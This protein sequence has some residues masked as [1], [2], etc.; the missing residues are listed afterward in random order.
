MASYAFSQRTVA[1]SFSDKNWIK[2]TYGGYNHCILINRSTGSVLPNCVAYVHGRW[3]ELLTNAIGLSKAKEYEA[4]MCLYNAEQYFGYTQDGFSRGQE[5]KLGAILCWRKGSLASGDGAGHVAI[6]EQINSDGSIVC[7]ASN[8]GGTRWYRSTYKKSN[9]Y[10]IGSSYTFQGF[11]YPPVEFSAF[12]TNAVTRDTNR[13][14]VH[15]GLDILNVRTGAGLGYRR[16]GYAERGYYNPISS[17]SADGYTWYQVEEG[18]WIASVQ[19]VTF[20]PAETKPTT[21]KVVFPEVSNGDKVMLERIAKEYSLK[22]EV[23]KN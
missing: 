11:I 10:Y 23:S 2:T 20:I 5:P 12:A 8:Y 4:K 17:Q 21:F 6:V 14:Q 16:L 9:N 22:I 1:P 15:V 3:L 19:G 18:K 13:D 7:S